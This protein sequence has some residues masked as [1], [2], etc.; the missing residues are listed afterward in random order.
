MFNS[1][2]ISNFIIAK[3]Q[4][5]N[6][7]AVNKD[8]T[9]LSD[10]RDFFSENENNRAINSIMRVMEHI[11]ICSGLIGVQKKENCKFTSL[12]MLPRVAGIPS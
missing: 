11:N 4:S 7:E 8:T 6:L 1:L 10:L 2:K 9:M 3:K 5:L 12:Q